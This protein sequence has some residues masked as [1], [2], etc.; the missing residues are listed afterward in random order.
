MCDHRLFLGRISG[1]SIVQDGPA[2]GMYEGHAG[3]TR[4]AHVTPASFIAWVGKSLMNEQ[5]R[6]KEDHVTGIMHFCTGLFLSS[7]NIAT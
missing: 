3:E 2:L 1:S 7:A 5:G 6:L 4:D